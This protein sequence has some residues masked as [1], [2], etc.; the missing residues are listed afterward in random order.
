MKT[1]ARKKKPPVKKKPRLTPEKAFLK[2]FLALQSELPELKRTEKVNGGEHTYSYT[3]LPVMRKVL[4]PLLTKHGFVYAW[5]SKEVS[6]NRIEYTCI[7]THIEGHSKSSSIIADKDST[8]DM[9][10]VQAVG[11]TTTYLQRYTLKAVLGLTSADDD[12]DGKSAGKKNKKEEIP[13]PNALTQ[14]TNGYENMDIESLM[15]LTDKKVV[16]DFIKKKY[17]KDEM[18]L[19]GFSDIEKYEIKE[20]LIK[21]IKENEK[22]RK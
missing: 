5:D 19:F 6:N 4:Q 9:N 14:S 17:K 20:F 1:Q 2:A 21:T 10:N 12:D 11:S 7:L 18:N 15:I 13:G 16:K 3:P 22:P 8:A